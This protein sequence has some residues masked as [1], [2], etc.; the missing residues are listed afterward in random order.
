[1]DVYTSPGQ[2]SYMNCLPEKDLEILLSYEVLDAKKKW[3][4]LNIYKAS[5][6]VLEEKLQESFG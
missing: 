3:W 1:M 6:K 2:D 4:F 5:L